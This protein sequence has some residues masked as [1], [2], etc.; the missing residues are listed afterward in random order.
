MSACNSFHEDGGSGWA[1]LM[2]LP[3]SYASW[4]DSRRFYRQISAAAL[5]VRQL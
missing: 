5:G 1:G 4:W 3:G 2:T